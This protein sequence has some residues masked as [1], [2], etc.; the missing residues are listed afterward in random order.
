MRHLLG[1][2]SAA[3]NFWLKD[4]GDWMSR[5]ETGVLFGEDVKPDLFVETVQ[6]FFQTPDRTHTFFIQPR[7]NY[8]DSD[9]NLFNLGAGYRRYSERFDALAGINIFGDYETRHRH[10]RTGIGIEWLSSPMDIRANS[11][12]GLTPAREV[13][14]PS[15]GPVF[16]K[17]AD[18]LDF[19]VGVP[20]PYVPHT[21]LFSGG[22]ITFFEE[23][24]NERYGWRARVEMKPVPWSTLSAGLR[25][26]NDGPA[27]WRFDA[28]IS[29]DLGAGG[30]TH[31]KA[32]TKPDVKD[33]ALERVERQ[34]RMTKEKFGEG[35]SFFVAKA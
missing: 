7:Y 17:V 22:Q 18:G 10:G 24:G 15:T 29:V 26:E 5:V 8:N 28:R 1:P 34:H 16:E 3:L 33:R 31:P 20:L 9:G 32:S 23:T 25:D 30:S 21:K 19:E 11:Y 2:A 27:E 35:L 4:K 13:E 6:P 14:S 12:I